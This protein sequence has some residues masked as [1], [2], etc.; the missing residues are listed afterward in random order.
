MLTT[1]GILFLCQ[2]LDVTPL[3]VE[4]GDE[5]KVQAVSAAGQ[6]VPGLPVAVTL[7]SGEARQLGATDA[8]GIVRFRPEVL[9]AYVY[10]AT[11]DGVRLL[12]PHSAVQATRRWPYIFVAVPLGLAFLFL[13]LRSWWRDR[14]RRDAA[15]SAIT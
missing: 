3:P 11:L 2:H 4:L 1:F 8:A 12:S 6:P 15:A 10:A 7:P 14:R 13:H 5:V 9:G